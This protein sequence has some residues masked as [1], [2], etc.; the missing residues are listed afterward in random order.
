MAA[1]GEGMARTILHVDLNKFYA[2]V[3]CL[4]HPELLGKPV[5]VS[6][7]VENRQGIILAKKQQVREIY[8]DDT[9]KIE[10]FDIPRDI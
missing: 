1:V 5:A 4:Y 6:G 3:E 8:A 7:D 2:K 9:D 10:N